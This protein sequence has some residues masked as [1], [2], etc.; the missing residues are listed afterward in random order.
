MKNKVLV[1]AAHPDDEVLGCGGTIFKHSSNGDDVQIV[2]VSDGVSS[3]N[4]SQDDIDSRKISAIKASK[5]LGCFEH[6]AINFVFMK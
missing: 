5:I 4:F 3:R 6:A 1:L 2:F